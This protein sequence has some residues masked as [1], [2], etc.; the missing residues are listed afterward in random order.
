MKVSIKF[1]KKFLIL[2]FII[3]F[4]THYC[5]GKNLYTQQTEIQAAE[6]FV[7]SDGMTYTQSVIG[8]SYLNN[9]T[10]TQQTV[11]ENFH[12]SITEPQ[13]EYIV[14]NDVEE[15]QNSEHNII[16]LESS[17]NTNNDETT[18]RIFDS[19]PKNTSY[20]TFD[21]NNDNKIG[22]EEMIY[23]LQIISDVKSNNLNTKNLGLNEEISQCGGFNNKA[24]SLKV[25][26][27]PEKLI[28]KY[29]KESQTV[30]FIN[31]N[32]LLNCCGEHCINITYDEK[33][34]IFIIEE[35]DKP[36]MEGDVPLRCSCQCFYDFKIELPNI[37]SET[38]NIKLSRIISDQTETPS[39]EWSGKLN[40]L[41]VEGEELIKEHNE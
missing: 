3:F 40:L 28:W 22:L 13:Q 38:I 5:Y 2:F 19:S 17:E 23:A 41:R 11:M 4:L 21:V 37:S 29:D 35:T 25:S 32:V 27:E 33:I 39:T 12:E 15:V 14:E 10:I 34:N 31:N 24:K 18:R 30:I 9:E 20:I 7:L 1:I 6:I 36:I 16:E 26:T 8:N